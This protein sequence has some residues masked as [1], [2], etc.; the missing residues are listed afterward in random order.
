MNVVLS[1]QRAGH[2]LRVHNAVQ[3]GARELSTRR[4]AAVIV[5]RAAVAR[6]IR[7]AQVQLPLIAQRK[8]APLF[9]FIRVCTVYYIVFEY[10]EVFTVHRRCLKEETYGGAR[11]KHAV[12]HVAAE[13]HAEHEVER[14]ADAHRVART[15]TR[16]ALRAGGDDARKLALLLAAGQAADREPAEL[17]CA[18]LV[19]H[20]LHTHAPK[21][22]LQATLY[23]R[24][25][26]L[27]RRCGREGGVCGGV[28]GGVAR[29]GA[30]VC[31]RCRRGNL[32]RL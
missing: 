14:V 22:E 12:E 8:A 16:Q 4:T 1:K 30:R 6:H 20:R 15:R 7:F 19:E 25:Q 28:C 26:R 10:Y 29:C 23:D 11:G 2:S 27:P 32:A 18:P 9:G 13:R 17:L 24:E 5:D 21:L 31:R 3:V